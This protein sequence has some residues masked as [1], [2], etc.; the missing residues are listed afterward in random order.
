MFGFS[1]KL[2]LEGKGDVNPTKDNL[3]DGYL[4]F[5]CLQGI[6]NNNT[7]LSLCEFKDLVNNFA[8]II[9]YRIYSSCINELNIGYQNNIS[10]ALTDKNVFRIFKDLL[11]NCRYEGEKL[12]L[13]TGLWLEGTKIKIELGEDVKCFGSNF[14][15]AIAQFCIFQLSISNRVAI[16]GAVIRG[17][18]KLREITEKFGQSNADA[19]KITSSGEAILAK[20]M[21]NGNEIINIDKEDTL[22]MLDAHNNIDGIQAQAYQ[23]LIAC[24]GL[25]LTYFEGLFKGGSTSG[26]SLV[27]Q[28]YEIKRALRDLY[29]AQIAPIL[30]II[31]V[32]MGWGI[33]NKLNYKQTVLDNIR[34]NLSILEFLNQ[35]MIIPED[36]KNELVANILG[37]FVQDGKLV[38][39]NIVPL[40]DSDDSQY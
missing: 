38:T 19:G 28:E 2:P 33:K 29:A 13:N 15:W 25:P 11:L 17:I 1:K 26:V 14:F 40:K 39:E 34:D 22:T 32:N 24:T 37:E 3:S 5:L 35:D 16:S 4:D 7:G 10:E 9:L 18:F 20:L 12:T 36:I 6:I 30:K 21:G 27:Q 8:Y 23:P 31:D